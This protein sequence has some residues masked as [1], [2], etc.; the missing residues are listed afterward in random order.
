MNNSI[1][2]VTDFMS[3]SSFVA[4]CM[5][6]TLGMKND[7]VS[8]QSIKFN[9]S[10]YT[11]YIIYSCR[12]RLCFFTSN[13][14][15]KKDCFILNSSSRSWG[16]QESWLSWK[17]LKWLGNKRMAHGFL[18]LRC[19]S[20][21]GH[22][23]MG[24]KMLL[25]LQ[26][27]QWNFPWT[28]TWLSG[29]SEGHNQAKLLSCSTAPG[30]DHAIPKPIAAASILPGTNCLWTVGHRK[31]DRPT[32]WSG[33]MWC[34][35]SPVYSKASLEKY[36]DLCSDSHLPLGIDDPKSRSAIS[37]KCFLCY[38]IPLLIVKIIPFKATLNQS[39]CSNT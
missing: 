24:H 35:S 29:T 30:N 17:P 6:Y 32:L 8:I 11:V 39:W 25:N 15:M 21:I 31:D 22:L 14:T 13:S 10:W 20:W 19:I 1:A 7:S 2:V 36:N 3:M 34:P 23:Y 5:Y 27:A 33:N 37:H 38:K 9:H 12:P 18:D 28:P 16:E 4:T 26:L